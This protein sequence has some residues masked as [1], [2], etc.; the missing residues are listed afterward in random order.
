M[1]LK[2]KRTFKGTWALRAPDK[3]QLLPVELPLHLRVSI[4]LKVI[5]TGDRRRACRQDSAIKRP[6]RIRQL[7]ERTV[8]SLAKG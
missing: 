6:K 4:N 7:I 3:P 2:K 5:G 1:E 8:A